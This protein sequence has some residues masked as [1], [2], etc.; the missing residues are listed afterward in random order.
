M[1]NKLIELSIDPALIHK[2]GANQVSMAN[3]VYECSEFAACSQ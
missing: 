1:V 2:I 3:Y